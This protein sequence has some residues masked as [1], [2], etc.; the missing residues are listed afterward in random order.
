MPWKSIVGHDRIVEQCREAL[1]RGRLAHAYLFVG[2]EGVGKRLFGVTLA[3][4]LLCEQNA[5]ESLDPCQACPGC[6]QVAA[7]AHPDFFLVA[8]PE[9]KHEMPVELFIGPREQR[10][11][12][13]L[14]HDLAQKPARG[15]YKIAVI[16][17]ADFFNAESAN[18]LLKTL[19]E[20]PPRSLLILIGSNPDLQLPTIRSRCTLVR[21]APLR[22][23]EIRELLLGRGIVDDPARA[24]LL[25]ALSEGSMGRAC[26]MADDELWEFRRRLLELLPACGL[27]GRQGVSSVELAQQVQSF[28]DAAGSESARQRS[29]ARVLIGFCA[30]LYRHALWNSCGAEIADPLDSP[31]QQA[32]A[33]LSQR[34]AP[35]GGYGPAGT[36]R[37][38]RLLERCLEADWH[39]QRRV[40]LP[41]AMEAFF[42]D[43]APPV[44]SS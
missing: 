33:A 35:G 30:Q 27:E 26:E 16:D 32:V 34:F 4:A 29:R 7:G 3:Q 14:C 42:D 12:V 23:S 6:K 24:D 10:G 1:A 8:K 2:P 36:D 15:G 21:F 19:E 28:V 18:S 44:A 40:Q 41:L 9:N 43:L 22:A 31:H 25:A 20:P 37:L 38:R 17:D 11:R 39:I 5:P 13:G